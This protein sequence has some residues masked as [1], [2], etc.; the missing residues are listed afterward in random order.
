MTSS[1]PRPIA[2]AMLALVA[3]LTLSGCS[4]LNS[5]LPS[6]EPVRDADSGEIT[7]GQDRADVFQIRVGDCLN[8]ST[9]SDEVN[10]VPVVPCAESHEDEV[11][12]AFDLDEGDFPGEDVI[13]AKSDEMCT[14]EFASFIGMSY[15]ESTLDWY[16]FTPTAGS[17]SDGDREILCVAYD[18][19]GMTTGTLAGAAR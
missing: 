4:L 6:S 5:V 7:E 1:M 3:G 18:P 14:P 16:P 19:A 13:D 12:F 10:A 15:E 9:L 8:T 11:Y 2:L 17:W